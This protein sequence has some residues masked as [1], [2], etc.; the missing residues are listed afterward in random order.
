[1]GNLSRQHSS[2]GHLSRQQSTVSS[3][4]LKDGFTPGSN[5]GTLTRRLSHLSTGGRGRGGVS[6]VPLTEEWILVPGLFVAVISDEDEEEEEEAAVRPA[7]MAGSSGGSSSGAHEAP[8]TA[9]EVLTTAGKECW[10][11]SPEVTPYPSPVLSL[12]IPSNQ[13]TY[14]SPLTSYPP[15]HYLSCYYLPS[16]LDHVMTI[17]PSFYRNYLPSNLALALV[18]SPTA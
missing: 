3:S 10:W 6:T 11:W 15:L 16:K 18:L 12:L 2:V 7:D 14:L 8:R 1:M 4:H 17:P 5:R 13:T 9:A